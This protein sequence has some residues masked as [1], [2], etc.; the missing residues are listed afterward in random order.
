MRPTV[1][2]RQYW[3]VYVQIPESRWRVGQR[4]FRRGPNDHLIVHVLQGEPG[5][6]FTCGTSVNGPEPGFM[7]KKDYGGTVVALF[8]WPQ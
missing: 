6:Y 8:T 4:V 1:G 7:W 2:L 5:A 3:M